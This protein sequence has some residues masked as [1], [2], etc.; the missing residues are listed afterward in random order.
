MRKA[1]ITTACYL[2]ALFSL[3]QKKMSVTEFVNPFIGTGGHGHTYPGATVPFGLVQLSPDTRRE[4]W[5]GCGGYHYTDS[6]LFGFSHTHLQGTGISDYSDILF[7]PN[8]GH[9]HKKQHWIDATSHAF[10]HQDEYARPGYYAVHLKDQNIQVQ[11]TATP[12]CGIHRYAFNPQDTAYLFIDMAY[13]D[14]L[15]YYDLVTYGDT[16]IAGYRVSKEWAEEQHCYFYAV[17]SHPIKGLDQLSEMSTEM[18]NGKRQDVL[19]MIQTFRLSFGQIGQLDIRVGISGTD[20]EGAKKNLYAEAP[21]FNFEVYQKNAKLTWE[22]KLKKAP[23][24]TL[25]KGPSESNNNAIINY[26]TALYH[27]YT[28]PNIW[29]DVDGRY[30]GEDKKIHKA[31]GYKR[32]TVFSLWD[33]FRAYHPLMTQLEPEATLDWIKTFLA[34]YNE[35]GEL[36]MWE[37]A[38]NETY[39]MIGSHSIPVILEAYVQGIRGFDAELALKAMID[40]TNGPEPEKKR[41]A[42]MGFVP[43]DEFSESVS[44]TLEYAYNDWCVAEMDW[45]LHQNKK[46][47]VY[48][49]Y[50]KR[51]QSW[52]NIF[53]PVTHF[54]RPRRNGGFIEPFD[55]YQVDFNFTEANAWQYALFVPHDIETLVAFHGGPKKFGE[56]LHQL[57]TA[58][59]KTTGREQADITGLIGQYA[60]GNEPS[61]HCLYLFPYAHKSYHN[62]GLKYLQQTIEALYRNDPDGLCGNEDCG[63][64]SAWLVCAMNGQ[65]KVAPGQGKEWLAF[66]PYK[67]SDKSSV[68]PTLKSAHPSSL[69]TAEIIVP[70]PIISGPA[71]SFTEQATIAIHHA[72]EN[73][74]IEVQVKNIETQNVQT[75]TYGQP[76]IIDYAAEVTAQAFLVT[77]NGELSSSPAHAIFR[78]RDALKKIISIGEYDNQY[79]GGG[80]DALI[81][82]ALGGKDFRTGGWQGYYGKPLDI[83]VDLGRPTELASIGLSVHQDIKTWIWYPKSVQFYGTYP[84]GRETFLGEIVCTDE[85]QVYGPMQKVIR[86][87][88]QNKSYFKSIRIAAQSAFD[89][90]PSWH[91]GQGGKSWIFSDEILFE[92]ADNTEK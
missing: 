50:S 58:K 46:S 15:Q 2:L 37:L 57:F 62:E 56:F 75:F 49:T 33:T 79:T 34:I 40:A 25:T 22:E 47:E 73:V 9:T 53:D 81:D 29:S 10:S 76:F 44:K 87:D 38:G 24:P 30:R 12:H 23:Y 68:L 31:E 78:T 69:M 66:S 72:Y 83:H 32:Y 35:R 91:L 54:M 63:Q 64:M 14:K 84:D 70:L 6:I 36:P 7:T 80:R 18:V 48:L 86:F 45:L 82:G 28:V 85:Q 16:A 27:C 65:Y 51:A 20:I 8:N 43:A 89:V 67:I 92:E 90:I 39:C 17:F 13:R 61:H 71:I 1:L 3:G 55:P 77:K 59:D 21:H 19:E 41:Y 4:G 88:I 26:Y 74:R 5:D 52:K 60:H 42:E 11:L